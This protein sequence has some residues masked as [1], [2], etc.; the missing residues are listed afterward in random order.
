[1]T[2]PESASEAPVKRHLLVF[3]TA[4]TWK[5]LNERNIA[6]IITGRDQGGWFDHVWTV[7]PVASLLE[8]ED[9]P[10]RFGRPVVHDLAPRHTF[11]EGKIGRFAALRRFEKL[12]FLL[13][14]LSLFLLLIGI[15]LRHRFDIV[16]SEEV[17]FAGP[18]A[19]LFAR[20]FRKPVLIGVWGNP[21]AQRKHTGRPLTPRLFRTVAQEEKV[22]RFMLHRADVV[23]I[24]NE[25]NRNYV[26][27][28]GIPRE[29]TAL[30]RVGNIIER[31]HFIDPAER[32]DGNADLEAIGATGDPTILVVARLQQVKLIDDVIRAAGVLKERGRF[33]KVLLAGEGPYRKTLEALAA[34]LGVTDRIMF[35]GDCDQTWLWRVVPKVS[36]IVSPLTGRAMAEMAL[37]AAPIVA[38]DLDWQGELIETGKTG[39]LVPHLDYVAMADAIERFLDDP[40]YARRMGDA[41]RARTLEMM[42]PEAN[43]RMQ[44]EVYRRLIEKS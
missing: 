34:E 1:M 2:A 40:A 14:Q 41:V 18:M 15:G 20:L 4:Y 26:L 19:W 22:E 6:A 25:D 39:E 11:I 3:D 37:G 16:R 17:Y 30:F 44:I 8:P 21:G 43:D 35:L 42:D 31:H 36:M 24:Q 29:R 32:P 33:V 27:S 13:A 9:S 28:L 23:M 38:Y 12:N 10:P 7:H 5:I